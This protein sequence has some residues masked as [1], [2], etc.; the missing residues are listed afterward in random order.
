M[1]PLTSDIS[2]DT[3]CDN[4]T[5]TPINPGDKYCDECLDSIVE[6]MAVEFDQQYQVEQGWY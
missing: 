2:L 4:C 5:V 3:Y 6:N 1:N